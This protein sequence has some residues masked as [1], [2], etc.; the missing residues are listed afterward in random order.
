MVSGKD[1]AQN[2]NAEVFEAYVDGAVVS[3]DGADDEEVRN[4]WPKILSLLDRKTYYNYLSIVSV[5]LTI[6]RHS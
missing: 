4:L 1:D 2:T 5:S 3:R 6:L